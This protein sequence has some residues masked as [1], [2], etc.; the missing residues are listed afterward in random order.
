[1]KEKFFCARDKLWD[2]DP[3]LIKCTRFVPQGKVLDLGL[4]KEG[5]NAL[6]S[7]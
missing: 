3:L 4:G 7:N 2:F 6:V 5:R 1:M